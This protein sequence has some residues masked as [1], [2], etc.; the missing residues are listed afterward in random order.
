MEPP[1]TG[2]AGG[3]ATVAAAGTRVQLPDQPART[4]SIK[5]L[6]ANTGVIYVGGSAVAA[7]NGYPLSAGDAVDI[8]IE[9]LSDLWIDASANGQ[10]VA[11]LVVS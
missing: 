10:S 11:W 8:A 6:P 4:C 7:A 5:A 2:I 9:N 3:Q 1:A